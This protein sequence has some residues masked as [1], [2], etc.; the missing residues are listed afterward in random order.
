M[1]D[2]EEYLTKLLTEAI[3]RLRN[4]LHLNISAGNTWVKHLDWDTLKDYERDIF[5]FTVNCEG[6]EFTKAVG[7]GEDGLLDM[8]ENCKKSF[9]WESVKDLPIDQQNLLR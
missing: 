3:Y 7:F 8:S 5:H 1:E 2:F 4:N 6:L 9:D